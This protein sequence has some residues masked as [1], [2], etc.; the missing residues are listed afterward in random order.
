M[1]ALFIGRFQPFH[2]GHLHIIKDVSKKY[3][4]IIIGIGSSQ[5]SNTLEN[6][7]SADERKLMIKKS[8]D[9]SGVINYKIVL[10]PDIHNPP[11]WVDHVLSIFSDFDVVITNNSLTKRLFF[12]KGFNV[13]ETKLYKKDIYSG[14]IIRLKMVND[15]QWRNSVPLDVYNIIKHIKGVERLKN[16]LQQQK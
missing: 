2:N 15:E 16:L 12:E 3:E 4:K 13:K 10:I 14:K 8:L 1:I 5:Y 7:F 9:N 6:P 11:K